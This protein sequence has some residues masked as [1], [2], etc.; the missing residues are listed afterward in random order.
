MKTAARKKG[1]NPEQ[2]YTVFQVDV[3]SRL[4]VIETRQNDAIKHL[5]KI[6]GTVAAHEKYVQNTEGSLR[7]VK[8]VAGGISAVVSLVVYVVH[9]L[10]H[11]YTP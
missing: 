8:Y 7:V 3:I 1:T 4:S 2:N 10:L 9:Y 11:N 5:E 6:N